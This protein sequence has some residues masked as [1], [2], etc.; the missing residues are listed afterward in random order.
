MDA[1]VR[2]GRFR[3]EIPLAFP[4]RQGS[5]FAGIVRGVGEG[6]RGFAVRDEVFGHDPAHGAYA[7]HVV[8]PADALVR[9]PRTLPWEVAATLHLAGLTAFT[10]TQPLRL[11][12]RDTVVVTAAAGGVGHLECQ[13]AR[14]SGARVVGIAG[15]ENHDYLRSIGVKPVGYDD[16]LLASVREAAGGPVTALL[17][18]FGGYEDLA[19]R[20]DVPRDRRV[21]SED[22]RD[23]EIALYT[24]PGD[25]AEAVRLLD[26]AELV[27]EWNLRVLVSGFYPFSALDRAFEDLQARHSRGVI[28]VGMDPSAPPREYL[29]GKL[30]TRYETSPV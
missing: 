23:V 30:R 11:T 9:K 16:D 19:D 26:V 4:A 2:E 7:T 24:A 22:R 8:V 27:A 29:R 25:R 12:D 13:L 14:L 5:G 18:N 1:Y 21:R 28:V 15:R 3:A 20:L 17:D 10:L 6:V